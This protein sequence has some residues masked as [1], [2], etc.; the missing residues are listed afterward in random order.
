MPA[1]TTAQAVCGEVRYISGRTGRNTQSRRTASIARVRSA[2]P[3]EWL[4]TG[5]SSASTSSVSIRLTAIGR[6][7][8]V[9]AF[10]TRCTCTHISSRIRNDTPMW[11]KASSEKK[12][13]V[14]LAG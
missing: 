1:I 8:C 6:G 12:R 2:M 13:S 3:S 10:G 11:M 5:S 4:S 9:D 7:G 14:M